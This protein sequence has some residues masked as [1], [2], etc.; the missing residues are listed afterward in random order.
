MSGHSKWSTIKRQKQ[1]TDQARGKIFTKLGNAITIAI[2]EGGGITSP[3]SNFRLRLAIDQAK[4]ANMPKENIQRAIHRALGKGTDQAV[5]K[6]M[7]YE[8]FAPRGI[9]VLVE[10]VTDNP[11]RTAQAVKNV[12]ATH[13]GSLSGTGSVLYQF[14]KVGEIH[15][16]ITFAFDELF[17]VAAQAGAQDIETT[18]DTHIV[19]ASYEKLNDVKRMLEA[20]FIPIISSGLVYRPISP[21][22]IK[23]RQEATK[24]IK[25]LESLDDLDDVHKVYV[26]ANFIVT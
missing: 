4:S 24:L 2:R 7:V 25:L 3:E 9:G 23:D 1:A 15:V 21:I 11:Q 17:D 12:F 6:E 8:G 14:Q 16:P 20:K 19:Y 13:G 26:N 18:V 22:E 5:L 10:G